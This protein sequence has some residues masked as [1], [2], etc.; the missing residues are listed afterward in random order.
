MRQKIQRR[1]QVCRLQCDLLNSN[2]WRILKISREDLRVN[3]MRGNN[4]THSV[5]E[6]LSP[7]GTSCAFFRAFFQTPHHPL[8]GSSLSTYFLSGF[9][10]EF[11]W[12]GEMMV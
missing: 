4:H 9:L 6:L 1:K 7:G 10:G 5:L 12:G 8:G 3:P 2:T 11:D